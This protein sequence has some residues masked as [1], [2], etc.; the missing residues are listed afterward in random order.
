[1]PCQG[2][3]KVLEAKL[4]IT[5]TIL[6]GQNAVQISSS[7]ANKVSLKELAARLV[8]VGKVTYNDFMLTLAL[9]SQEMVVFP[10]GRTI[11]KNTVDEALA[12]ELYMK[13]VS[14]TSNS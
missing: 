11:I 14:E 8:A 1:L 6:H 5:A 3:F 13:Y 4:G 10:D 12:Q 9:D 2:T 7:P